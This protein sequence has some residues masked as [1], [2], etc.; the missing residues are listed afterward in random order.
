[1]RTQSSSERIWAAIRSIFPREEMVKHQLL[2]G[3][4]GCSNTPWIRIER[5]QTTLFTSRSY[6]VRKRCLDPILLNSEFYLVFQFSRLIS[7]LVHETAI[8]FSR[9]LKPE[10]L[11]P[12]GI[13]VTAVRQTQSPNP[14]ADDTS[15][16][17]SQYGHPSPYHARQPNHHCRREQEQNLQ[18][19]PL[20]TAAAVT[21]SRQWATG[22]QKLVCTYP[23]Y[24]NPAARCGRCL[25]AAFCHA[26]RPGFQKTGTPGRC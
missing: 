5:Q 1:M 20:S 17:T 22:R 12:K 2:L 9:N 19:L 10:T 3:K 8:K 11:I 21:S 24:T 16:C 25:G 13:E 15:E 14:S 7:P 6:Y 18:N 26:G 23:E 4:R